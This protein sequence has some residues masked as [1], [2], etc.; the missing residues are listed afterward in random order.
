MGGMPKVLIASDDPRARTW[1][2]MALGPRWAVAEASDGL[3]ARRM[4]EREAPDLVVT[5]ETMEGYGAFGMAREIKA[6][7]K[8]PAVIVLLER[9]QDDWLARWSGADRWLLRPIDPFELL[10][11]ADELT[12]ARPAPVARNTSE[13]GTE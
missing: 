10:A 6:L 2:R 9:A 5:D 3:Q 4:V 12:A 1:V 11:V 13:E 7:S 8:A